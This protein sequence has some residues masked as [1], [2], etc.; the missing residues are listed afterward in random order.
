MPDQIK[1]VLSIAITV[2]L[3][4]VVGYGVLSDERTPE[5]RL[6]DLGDR[7]A[8][9]VC[10]GSSIADSPSTYARDMLTLVEEQI[11]AGRS[12][13]EILQFFEDRYSSAI[14]LDAPTSGNRILL[15]VSPF[16]VAAAGVYLAVGTRRRERSAQ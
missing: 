2:A 12:D 11:A 8:C 14:R 6:A 13:E 7:I 15:W 1:R 4:A 10:D 9:P 5:E 3:A 16:V